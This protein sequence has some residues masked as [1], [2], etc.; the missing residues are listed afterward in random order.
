MAP[1]LARRLV[2][3]ICFCCPGSLS[4]TGSDKEADSNFGNSANTQHSITN[5]VIPPKVRVVDIETVSVTL[6]QWEHSTNRFQNL[7]KYLKNIP[8]SCKDPKRSIDL[9]DAK[10]W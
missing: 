4:N 5:T 7:H 2:S 9:I 6:P 3:K 1:T 8:A 10:V